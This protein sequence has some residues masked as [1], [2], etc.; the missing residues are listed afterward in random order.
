MANI[1]ERVV[2]L[3]MDDSSLQQGVSRVTKALEQLKKAFKFSDTKSFE[4]LDKAAKKVKFDSV[5]KSASDMQKS[6]NQATNKAT[7]DFAE[8]GSGAQKASNRSEQQPAVFRSMMS[9]AQPIRWLHKFRD[10]QVRQMLPLER[11]EPIPP[12]LN[13]PMGLWPSSKWQ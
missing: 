11:S 2:K 13:K 10:L 8:M 6:I 3:S 1:D 12:V 7:N 4:E 9:L 5:S